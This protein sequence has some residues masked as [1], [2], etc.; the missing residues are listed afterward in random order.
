MQC[1]WWEIHGYQTCRSRAW[2]RHQR[3]RRSCSPRVPESTSSPGKCW[4]S[5]FSPHAV[6]VAWQLLA[7][8]WLNTLLDRDVPIV[9]SPRR[10]LLTEW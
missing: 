2:I 10:F 7:S 8:S 3:R 6:L 5:H 9:A 1:S 4:T